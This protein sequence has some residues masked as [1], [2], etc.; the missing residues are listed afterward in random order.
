MRGFRQSRLLV[1]LIAA[2]VVV[3]VAFPSVRNSI[4]VNRPPKPKGVDPVEVKSVRQPKGAALDHSFS[5]VSLHELA[6]MSGDARFT[7]IAD[8][9][10]ASTDEARIAAAR[11][12]QKC[13]PS[14]AVGFLLEASLMS[15]SNEAFAELIDQAARKA[16]FSLF[17]IEWKE[18]LLTRAL[19]GDPRFDGVARLVNRKY[20]EDV[21]VKSGY[22]LRSIV[23]RL[24][25]TKD[26]SLNDAIQPL[27][28]GT[29]A[30][31]VGRILQESKDGLWETQ[32]AGRM[33]E[34][35]AL[36]VRF[37]TNDIYSDSDGATVAERLLAIREAKDA[38]DSI[39][40]RMPGIYKMLSE[41]ESI[42]LDEILLHQGQV[43]AWKWLNASDRT[44]I[45]PT[46]GN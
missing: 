41:A 33:I 36:R 6:R 35:A 2:G 10:A 44:Y 19:D 30:V 39:T 20:S 16:D 34:E 32:V 15:T 26:A 4:L 14:N 23:D 45:N 5:T 17:A 46:N 9:F 8:F 27:W 37:A 11:N 43:E 13:E 42:Q 12:L 31:R 24:T 38:F 29:A 21:V 40:R 1:A 3:L 7:S 22:A 25:R 28:D 18:D